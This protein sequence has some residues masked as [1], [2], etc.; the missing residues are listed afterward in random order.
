MSDFRKLWYLDKLRRNVWLKAEQLLKIQERKLRMIVNHA[1][2]NVEYYHKKFNS[3]GLKPEDIKNVGDLQKLPIITKEEVRKNF[4]RKITARNINL[5][6]CKSYS[7]SGSTGIPLKVL[8][9]PKGNDYRAALFGRAFFECGLKLRDK[10]MMVGDAR[11]FPKKSQWFQKLGVLRRK[12]FSAAEPVEEQLSRIVDYNPEAIFGYSSYL[13][14]LA[15]EIQ[16]R[17]AKQFSPRLVF[18]TAEVLGDEER[19]FIEN[20]LNTEIFDLYGC[21][22]VERLA[23]ECEEHVGYHMDIDSAIIEFVEGNE[24]VSPGEEGKIIVT[25]LYN[26]AMPLIRYELG[27]IGVPSNEECPCG[28]G[29]PLA[30]KILGRQDDFIICPSGRVI[31]SPIIINLVRS[32]PGI[33]QYKFVQESLTKLKIYIVKDEKFSDRTIDQIITEV[34]KVVGE[35]MM[36]VPSVVERIEKERSGKLRSVTSCVKRPEA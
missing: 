30:D 19:K 12:Y 26:Y 18:S 7:T 9:D 34:R 15:K 4:P 13:F 16:K 32:I 31:F 36:I 14:L 2:E 27:D 29:F 35:D 10:M 21:V 22:E 28:R 11:H 5:D 8:I 33:A 1:Y 23:W 25:C 20:V 17:G 24:T 6:K 3:L